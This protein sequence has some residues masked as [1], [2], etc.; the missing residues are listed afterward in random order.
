MQLKSMHMLQQSGATARDVWWKVTASFETVTSNCE[1][2]R[3]PLAFIT[4]VMKLFVAGLP[5]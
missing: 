4:S 1:S 2:I 5:A 3:A